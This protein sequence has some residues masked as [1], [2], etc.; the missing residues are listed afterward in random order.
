MKALW[1]FDKLVLACVLGGLFAYFAYLQP[2]FLSYA[3]LPFPVL[4][5]MV[6]PGE[7]VRL[8]VQRCNSDSVTRIYGVSHL[9]VPV[10]PAGERKPIVLPASQTS[11]EPGC[12][13]SVSAINVVPPS[14]PP[15]LYVIEGYG[16]AQATL[17]AVSVRWVSQ[18]FEVTSP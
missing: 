18:P 9:M 7:P 10:K 6:R 4:N 14:T 11:I 8:S 1:V 15:G 16:E 13:E 12:H 17:R 3:N 2:P 5:A